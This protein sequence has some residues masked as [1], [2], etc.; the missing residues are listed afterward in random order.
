MIL[1]VRVADSRGPRAIGQ[2]MTDPGDIVEVV[3]D[4]HVFSPAELGNPDY[5]FLRV[6]LVAIEAEAL[7]APDLDPVTQRATRM[8][9]QGLPLGF[10]AGAKA[11]EIRDVSRAAFVAAVSRKPARVR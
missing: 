5:R 8:R 10:L 4:D 9:A 7:K 1:V 2:V 6:P 11:G 3:P